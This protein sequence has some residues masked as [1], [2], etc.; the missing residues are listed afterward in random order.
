[1]GQAPRF[2]PVP[3]ASS[4]GALGTPGWSPPQEGPL[5]AGELWARGGF[6]HRGAWQ[7]GG[8]GRTI[9]KG[10]HVASAGR[11]RHVKGLT[12]ALFG[13]GAALES[14]A[15]GPRPHPMPDPSSPGEWGVG[16]G[17]QG[18]FHGG[19][20]PGE[21]LRFGPWPLRR[22]PPQ[23]SCFLSSFKCGVW[24]IWEQAL[25]W[26]VARRDPCPCPPLLRSVAIS[27]LLLP[28]LLTGFSSA[29]SSFQPQQLRTCFS[30]RAAPSPPVLC[31]TFGCRSGEMAT[32]GW[33]NRRLS[34]LLPHPRGTG[35][36]IPWPQPCL[37]RGV[38]WVDG[39]RT[40]GS[41]I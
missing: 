14:P 38:L 15:R 28:W 25:G 24:R 9:W 13:S 41:G 7:R 33:W 20:V 27:H 35:A 31:R 10:G 40:H 30:L 4:L 8:R 5:G 37:H 32:G 23:C 18:Q 2:S 21:Q 22:I 11:E 3:L 26:D 29:A 19:K 6:T 39:V 1:M 16:R 17:S 34:P 12:E 36:S